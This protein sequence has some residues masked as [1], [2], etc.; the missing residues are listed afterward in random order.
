MSSS[1]SSSKTT[2]TPVYD[3]EGGSG[4][5]AV[6]DQCMMKAAASGV[7][8]APDKI[9]WLYLDYA[10]Y[11]YDVDDGIGSLPKEWKTPGTP[12]PEEIMK[13]PPEDRVYGPEEWPLPGAYSG[14][15]LVIRG[16]GGGY[17]GI[18]VKDNHEILDMSTVEQLIIWHSPDDKVGRRKL[19]HQQEKRFEARH[20]N[21]VASLQGTALHCYRG[22]NQ[23]EDFRQGMIART[24][25]F[26]RTNF[27]VYVLLQ[28]LG[29]DTE[30]DALRERWSSASQ[31]KGESILEYRTCLQNLA[32]RQHDLLGKRVATTEMATRLRA[33]VRSEFQLSLLTM[34]EAD[35][36]DLSKLMVFLL[37]IEQALDGQHGGQQ[38]HHQGKGGDPRQRAG[39]GKRGPKKGGKETWCDFHKTTSHSTEDCRGSNKR[40]NNGNNNGN[41]KGTKKSKANYD[42]KTKT[43][44][45]QGAR[46]R[47]ECFECGQP[48]HVARKC[49]QKEGKHGGKKDDAPERGTASYNT[50]GRYGAATVRYDKDDNDDC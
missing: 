16:N 9:Y 31:K 49:P 26:Q 39:S 37:R 50:K 20:A 18:N 6:L 35:K 25:A 22:L 13:G 32:D 17:G 28:R 30:K 27:L 2:P 29:T 14:T 15:N 45:R 38:H 40:G 3:G 23:E 7:G 4:V 36:S 5:Q 1:S 44:P 41:G 19:F 48:G 8:S 21:F 10:H 33:S 12:A 11:E 42:A 34:P 47:G 43:D 24:M 46:D